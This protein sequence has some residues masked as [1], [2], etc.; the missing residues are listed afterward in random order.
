MIV[1]PRHPKVRIPHPMPGKE[2]AKLTAMRAQAWGLLVHGLRESFVLPGPSA[3]NSTH[4]SEGPAQHGPC[5]QAATTGARWQGRKGQVNSRYR[6]YMG[7]AIF[8]RHWTFQH[9]VLRLVELQPE[10]M[11]L[12]RDWLAPQGTSHGEGARVARRLPDKVAAGIWNRLKLCG[13]RIASGVSWSC[14]VSQRQGRLLGFCFCFQGARRRRGCQVGR[15]MDRILT[16]TLIGAFRM[17]SAQ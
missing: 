2:A 11:I 4:F 15:R 9:W 1:W 5:V 13:V 3:A 12:A 7:A 14:R 8:G 16:R 6:Y 10:E 17:P